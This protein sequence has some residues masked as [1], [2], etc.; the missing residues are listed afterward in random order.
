MGISERIA[1]I[2]TSEGLTASA[3]A[4]KLGIQR[5]N[6]SHI[7]NGRSGPSL[8]LLQ[9]ILNAFPHYNTDW[10]VMGRGEIYRKPVQTSIFDIL[11]D[12]E[13]LVTSKPDL[14]AQNAVETDS[15]STQSADATAIPPMHQH[16]QLF[17]TEP[18]VGNNQ[19]SSAKAEQDAPAADLTSVLT[20]AAQR[21][22][23]IKQ[24]VVLYSDN[25]FVAYNK[26]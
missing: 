18:V 4:D 9:K 8:D 17:E 11:G 15:G 5:S 6:I 2:I 1:K 3:F 13:G 23:E 20:H 12:D 21:Q 14:A 24:V 22:A 25:T 10:L 26:Q 16:P 7:M 19:P